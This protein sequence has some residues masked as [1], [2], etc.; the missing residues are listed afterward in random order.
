MRRI[1]LL[2]CACALTGSVGVAQ[3]A[4]PDQPRTIHVTAKKYEFS[5][6][7]IQVKAGEPVQIV[8]ESTDAKHG[9]ECPDLG[10]K[11]VTFEKDKPV[12]VTFTPAKAGTF[13]FKCAN[14]CGF[15]H[16]RMKG[17]IVVSP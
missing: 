15:G 5:P 3:D 10:L 2:A 13:D 6:S 14:F 4:P 17:H 16:G 12:T 8:F 7:E 9:F 11:K 1:I